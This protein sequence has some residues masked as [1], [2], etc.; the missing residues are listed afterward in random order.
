MTP[1][2]SKKYKL[3]WLIAFLSVLFIIFLN[4][5]P[6]YILDEA[7]FTEASRE[8]FVSGN[9]W[10]PFY[11]G[12]L[13]VDKPPLQ[14]Y[15]SILGFYLFGVNAFGA[16][17][18]SGVFGVLTLITT[19]L[20]VKDFL[21]KRSAEK[22]LFVLISSFFFLQQFQLAVPDP[23]LVYFCSAA[24][25]SFYRFYIKQNP[26]NLLL[27]YFLLGLGVLTKGPVAIALPGLSIALFLLINKQIK[28]VFSY[29]PILGLIGILVVAAPWYYCVH[30]LTKGEWTK[31]FFVVNNLER[32]SGA[33]QGHG[34]PFI[35][36]WAYVLLGLFPFSLFLPQAINKALK[37]NK[38]SIVCFSLIIGIVFILF[39]S[40]SATKLPNYT[41]PCYPF[42]AILLG[43]Y[44]ENNWF[45]LTK[46]W[47]K[48]SVFTIVILAVLLPFVIYF[49]LPFD[50]NLASKNSL[51]LWLIP[52]AIGS[53]VGVFYLLN[54][55]FT[56]WFNFTGASFLLLAIVLFGII[57]PSLNK[58]NPVN[59]VN[60]HIGK[61][62]EIVVY[63]RMD[64]A[65]PFNY[66]RIFPIV[67]TPEELTTYLN[68]HPKAYV[69]SN[70]KNTATL[71]SIQ[72]LNLVLQKKSP[73]EYHI[74]K[75]YKRKDFKQ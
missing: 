32:F 2:T 9:F 21:N 26:K 54:G 20:F 61:K 11:N 62:A 66:Q 28:N 51:G 41:M 75:L 19:Y 40:L 43:H 47:N 7:K 39:F 31:G 27:C 60:N 4:A 34:G 8:M 1:F 70:I 12:K 16:R 14:N 52:T 25:F 71:D 59:I 36:T 65:F 13:F 38:N 45:T 15:F 73:F 67:E 18:F 44:F 69:M 49:G 63:K 5:S 3:L 48:I 24:L 23:Y 72:D 58:I 10:V 64:A 30:E 56:Y 17:F 6:I 22:T 53:L 33:M 35:V 74:T 29:Y 46:G 57:Y 37:L 42:L 50:P 55:K 68:K